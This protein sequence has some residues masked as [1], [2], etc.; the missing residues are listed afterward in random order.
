MA[1]RWDSSFGARLVSIGDTAIR[2]GTITLGKVGEIQLVENGV[3]N[4]IVPVN[5]MVSGTLSITSRT[6]TVSTGSQNISVPMGTVNRG[7][8]TGVGSTAG[9]GPFTVQLSSCSTGLNVYMTVTDGNNSSNISD[10]LSLTPG[11]Q[12]ATGIGIRITRQG[13]SQ[14]VSF[15][16]DSTLPGSAGQMS[17]G[18]TT[19][20]TMSIPFNSTYVQTQSFVTGGT[21][22]ALATFTMSYQ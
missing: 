17:F 20:E 18:A 7:T 3:T 16:V 12:A 21:A 5:L 14:R 1:S 19:G 10:V 9:G 13:N 22:N 2:T 15:G 4:A 11:A 8:F 6:C